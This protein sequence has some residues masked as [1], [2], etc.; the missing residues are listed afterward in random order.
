MTTVVDYGMGNLGSIINMI[1]HLGHTAQASGDPAVIASASRLILPGVGAFDAGM[2]QLIDSGLGTALEDCISV[3]RVPLLGICLGLHL[4]G[5]GSQEGTLPGLGW[6][7]ATAVKFSFPDQPELLKIPHMGWNTLTVERADPLLSNLP[8]DSRF[9]F[10]HSYYMAARMKEQVLATTV[11]G[12]PFPSV[13]RR[14]NVW[15]VQF[16]PEKSHRFGMKIL[17]NFLAVP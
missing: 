17:E 1:T 2:R 14:E 9:Y 16:H 13:M 7:D 11:H 15:G 8:Q 12:H 10:V 3:R 5:R 6:L 4:L